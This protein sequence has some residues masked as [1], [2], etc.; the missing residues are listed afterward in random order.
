[1]KHKITIITEN[2]PGVL[3]RIADLFLRRRINIESLSVKEFDAQA[4]LS[5][6]TIHINCDKDA[7]TRLAH[8]IKRIV[9]VRL[10]KHAVH[11]SDIVKVI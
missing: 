5:R 4:H 11:S 6:F 1:M 9:E 7:A 8:Q 2:K 10:V 3:Y